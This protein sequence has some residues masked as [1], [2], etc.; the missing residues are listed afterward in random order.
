M[1]RKN[2]TAWKL[3]K[4]YSTR[5]IMIQTLDLRMDQVFGKGIFEEDVDFWIHVS[6]EIVGDNDLPTFTS[7]YNE[8][9][10]HFVVSLPSLRPQKPK[11]QR[12]SGL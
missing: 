6:E 7:R 1:A 2:P 5:K 3:L 11:T 10:Q 9:Y 12:N 8:F 4:D